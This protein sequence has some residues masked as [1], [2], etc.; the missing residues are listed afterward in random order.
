MTA[1]ELAEP[2]VF[3]AGVTP[4]NLTR[5]DSPATCRSWPAGKPNWIGSMEKTA[6][7]RP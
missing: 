2:I 3:P 6:H 4:E 1:A 7:E 5:V